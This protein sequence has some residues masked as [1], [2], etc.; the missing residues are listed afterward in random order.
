M[1]VR[2]IS[3]CFAGCLA[4]ILSIA[5]FG[6]SA[7][8]RAADYWPVFGG[9]AGGMKYS[10]ADQI[11]RANVQ[12]L[13]IAW[14][15]KTGEEPDPQKGTAPGEF[16]ATP[17]MVGDTLYVSTPYNR[18]VALDASSGKEI[19]SYDPH[20]YDAGQ[21]P[22]SVG[23][24]HRGVAMWAN[25]TQR[26]IFIN[27]RW[28]LIALDAKTGKPIAEFGKQGEVDLVDV[29][30]WAGD[31]RHYGNTSPPVVFRNLVFVG[32]SVSD[33]LVYHNAPPGDVLA[34][35]ALTGR[36][37]WRFRTIPREG[38]FGNK[39]WDASSWQASGHANVWPPFVV[40]SERGLLYLPVTTGANDYYGGD[41]KGDNLFAD[42]LVC[43]N[44]TTGKRV[45]HFQTVHHGLWDYDGVMPPVLTTIHV[46]G[47]KI[48]AVAAPS[49]VGFVYVFDRVTGKPVWPIVERPVP[50]SDVPGEKTSVTQPFPTKPPPFAK[51]GFTMDDVVDFTPEIKALALGKLK[52][53]R[54]GPLFMPPS[55]EGTIQMPGNQGGA[56]W[57]GASFDPEIET[58]FV[59]SSNAP[60]LARVKKS[61]LLTGEE[62]YVGSGMNLTADGIPVQKPPYGV[63]TAIDLSKG[64]QIWQKPIGDTPAVRDHPLLKDL[65]L[66]ELGSVNHAGLLVTKG[67][68]IFSSGGDG[69]LYAVDER[70]GKPLWR[71][72]LRTKSEA[73]PMTYV[74]PSGRQ[75]VV[76]ATGAGR[77]A[78]LIA[79]ALPDGAPSGKTNSGVPAAEPMSP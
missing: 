69:Y 43:V 30:G 66:P 21:P 78:V 11:N 42:S 77:D 72:D 76:I 48:D 41:R 74:A 54:M 22:I 12:Q 68:L 13:Q 17:L 55:L 19:W 28:R 31:K 73:I 50:Q 70:D 75:Y 38:E 27:S 7:P 5:S 16:E 59:R 52:P 44:A 34:F 1:T 15:W 9:D 6:A 2:R 57:G 58:L 53:Y 47:K 40:D 33:S 61:K 36:L 67:G 63:I 32:N 37:A 35:D 56:N 46:N 18:A 8:D 62:T 65:T 45:W 23:F 20:A 51:Q 24:V 26:R 64:E 71:G 25:G 29:L 49:K 4:I 3:I 60:Y 79:F 39:T 10:R 14:R